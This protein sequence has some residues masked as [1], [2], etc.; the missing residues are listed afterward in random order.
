V[1]ADYAV[2]VMQRYRLAGRQAMKRV[3]VEAGG[4]VILC[5]LTTTFGYLA[6]TLSINRAI[7]SFG[8]AAATGEL[9]CVVAGVL[10][11]PAVMI[12][13]ARNSAATDPAQS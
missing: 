5:S 3:V 7:Q 12:W 8:I 4:A 13:R 10:V 11:L 2:N 1:G 9:C 6:L